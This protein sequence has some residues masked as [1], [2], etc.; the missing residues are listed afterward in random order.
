MKIRIPYSELLIKTAFFIFIFFTFFPKSIPFQPTLQEQSIDEI[1]E[2]NII[3]QIVNILIFTLAMLA[4]IPKLDSIISL[5]KKEKFLA[6]FLLWTLITILWSDFPFIS[7]KR[8]FQIFIFYFVTITFLSYYEETEVLK[9]IKPVIYVYILVT[10]VS[11]A[12]IPGAKDPEFNT[13]RGLA[14]TKNT[15]GQ[16]GVILSV[17][18]LIIFKN[19]KNNIKK[20][21]SITF[22]IASIIITLGT[23][24]STSYIALFVFL[25]GSYFFY[26][27]GQIFNKIGVGNFIFYASVFTAIFIFL[28][29]FLFVPQI[30]DFIQSVFGKSETFYDR[31]KLWSVMLYHI[32]QHPILGCGFQSFWTIENPQ[33]L[34]LYKTFVWLPNQAH[35][36]YLDI[37]NETGI[38]G[39]ISFLM[40]IF[41]II[42]RSTKFNIISLWLWF[43]ILPL[44]SNITESNFMRVGPI[45]T[46]FII[47]SYLTIEKII[48]KKKENNYV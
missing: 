24:S 27:K 25:I 41:S 17:L 18:T 43:L 33:L 47:L 10:L 39:L 2:G 48:M 29:F 7:F 4:A 38:I 22:F 1:G 19:E 9:V 14:F 3:N 15:L 42:Y 23:F 40:I 46:V 13:W 45:T 32:A 16:Y 28:I 11:I 5:I 36:G 35:N 21:I 44:I 26:L 20:Y 12:I 37:L 8:W 31:G 30:T 6:L 34:L